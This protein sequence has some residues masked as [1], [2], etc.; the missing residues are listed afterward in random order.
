[1]PAETTYKVDSLVLNTDRL[2]LATGGIIHPGNRKNWIEA[3]QLR[4][5]EEH[6]KACA[7]REGIEFFHKLRGVRAKL[8][9]HMRGERFV[10]V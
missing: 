3:T 1:M 9:R 2:R 6:T 5:S 8:K 7:T 4:D 10:T